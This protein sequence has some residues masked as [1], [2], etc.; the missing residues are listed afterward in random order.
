VP[1]VQELVADL[2]GSTNALGVWLMERDAVLAGAVRDSSI[3]PPRVRV[4]GE[5]WIEI[6]GTQVFAELIGR[7]TLVFLFDDT[8]SCGLIRLRVR[9]AKDAIQRALASRELR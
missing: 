7:A 5:T 4:D 1:S 8:S 2:L 9:H 3:T 6:G